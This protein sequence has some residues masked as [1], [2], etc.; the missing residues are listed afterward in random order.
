MSYIILFSS[1]FKRAGQYMIRCVV[2]RCSRLDS[3]GYKC[4]LCGG[5][6]GLRT[7]PCHVTVHRPQRPQE[8]DKD[9]LTTQQWKVRL[10]GNIIRAVAQNLDD[11]VRT[12]KDRTAIGKDL[13]A[14]F[15][16]KS[17]RVAR[18]RPCPGFD[19]HSESRLDEIRDHHGNERNA[20]LAR[21]TLL[22]HPN[23]HRVILLL[24]SLK[25]YKDPP[26]LASAHQDWRVFVLG[27]KSLMAPRSSNKSLT[28]RLGCTFRKHFVSAQ[29]RKTRHQFVTKNR[30]F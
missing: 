16:I 25:S 30:L 1:N 10:P 12:T 4:A 28:F 6:P 13:G 17:I 27:A 29:D 22:R 9:L 11:N 24:G 21:I 5:A 23:D 18:L 8:A 20:S 3:E 7:E 2:C 14:L 15:D 26:C 19:Q